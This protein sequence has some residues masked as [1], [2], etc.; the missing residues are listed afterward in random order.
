[1]PGPGNLDVM[2]RLTCALLPL[3]LL[4][5]GCG[6]S[7]S[8]SGTGGFGGLGGGGKPTTNTP[9]TNMPGGNTATGGTASDLANTAWYATGDLPGCYTFLA[10]Q[11]AT[12]WLSGDA[13][14]LDDG[15]VGVELYGGTYTRTGGNLVLNIQ[16]STCPAEVMGTTLN[17]TYTI[18]GTS[19][20]LNI[21]STPAMMV[22]MMK[23][24]PPLTGTAV[25]GCVTD[26]GR[27]VPATAQN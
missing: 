12:Q 10:F 24:E 1:M 8:S 20:A 22:N 11:T 26:D 14:P 6:D 15:S 16:Q 13:C 21:A 18:S 7:G 9:G 3:F 4:A 27:F 5:V 17:A 25:G 23:G 2:K 19:I